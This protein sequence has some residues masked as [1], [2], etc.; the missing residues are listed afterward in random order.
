MLHFILLN[1]TVFC[2]ALSVFHFV[3][4]RVHWWDTVHGDTFLT[5]QSSLAAGMVI[6]L[7]ASFR[8]DMPASVQAQEDVGDSMKCLGNV[9]GLQYLSNVIPYLSILY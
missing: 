3:Q 8:E 1:C 5:C 9:V 6:L 4:R 2:P 7:A